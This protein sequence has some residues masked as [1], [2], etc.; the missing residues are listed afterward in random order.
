VLEEFEKHP[1]SG[2]V[3][4]PYRVWNMA[5]NEYSD[6]A[7]F[8]PLSG[9]LPDRPL[10]LLRYGSFGTCGMALRRAAAEKVFP[11]PEDMRIYADTYLVLL[12]IFVAPVAAVNEH[13]TVYRHHG[14][15]S[16]AFR[17]QD[18]ERAQQRWRNYQ[19]GVEEARAWLKGNGYDVE[20][21]GTASYLER[22]ELMAEQLRFMAEGATRGKL[23]A[24]LRRELRVLGPLWSRR[25]R[26]YRELLAGAAYVLGYERYMNWQESYRRAGPALRLREWF[27]PS[28]ARERRAASGGA[29]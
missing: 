18:V 1:E 15:N 14:G 7:S 21:P 3:Y 26:L 28:A 4:H 17:G 6:D 8:T 20:Q 22:H 5:S 23:H 25:Y 29:R 13:F 11:I 12:M 10:N 9:Y 27:F 19:R 2:M 24:H 16:T